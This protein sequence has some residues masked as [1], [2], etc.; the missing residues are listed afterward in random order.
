MARFTGFYISAGSIIGP[1][2]SGRYQVVQGRIFGPGQT[3]RY[4]IA[5]GAI[6]GP[7]Q[8]GQFY[9]QDNQIFGPNSMLPWLADS[10]YIDEDDE[11]TTD[12]G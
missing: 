11:D 1:R 3:G 2:K 9:V 12:A 10:E 5:D 8:S 4:W 7:G 6:C